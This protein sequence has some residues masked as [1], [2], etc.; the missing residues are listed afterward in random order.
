MQDITRLREGYREIGKK[1]REIELHQVEEVEK[2]RH[3]REKG[4]TERKREINR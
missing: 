2:E 4:D 1:R 3:R